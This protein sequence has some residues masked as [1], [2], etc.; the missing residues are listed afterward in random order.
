MKHA[1]SVL[2]LLCQT[3]QYAL[4]KELFSLPHARRP[5]LRCYAA[6]CDI[7]IHATDVKIDSYKDLKIAVGVELQEEDLPVPRLEWGVNNIV[8]DSPITPSR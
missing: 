2:A 5:I 8:M 1:F 7:L 3:L 4:M 6:Y